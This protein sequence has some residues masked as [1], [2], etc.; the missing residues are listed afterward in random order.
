MVAPLGP[1][2]ALRSHKRFGVFPRTRPRAQ[3]A[4]GHSYIEP[5]GQ[6]L[7][8]RLLPEKNQGVTA[9]GWFTT[10]LSPAGAADPIAI[11]APC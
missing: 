8:A 10:R 4:T 6:V 7:D 9:V 5:A 1:R 2:T 11:E 3:G